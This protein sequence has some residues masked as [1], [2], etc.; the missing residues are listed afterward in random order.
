MRSAMPYSFVFVG[1]AA[2]ATRAVRELL[3]ELSG[4]PEQTASGAEEPR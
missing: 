4:S 2:I 3:A 1:L